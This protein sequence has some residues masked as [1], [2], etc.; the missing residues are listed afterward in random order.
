M[1]EGNN[2]RVTKETKK[3]IIIAGDLPAQRELMGTQT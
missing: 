1:C 2:R 3:P